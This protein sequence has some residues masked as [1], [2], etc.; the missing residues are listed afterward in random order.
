MISPNIIVPRQHSPGMISTCEEM[1]LRRPRWRMC[2]LYSRKQ[3]PRRQKGHSTYLSP[4]AYAQQAAVALSSLPT[5]LA[6]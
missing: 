5:P 3:M 1:T 6:A 4:G 2:A